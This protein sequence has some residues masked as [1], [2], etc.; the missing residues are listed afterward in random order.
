MKTIQLDKHYQNVHGVQL[1]PGTHDVQDDLARYLV[2]NGHAVY[3]ESEPLPQ[4]V[5]SIPESTEDTATEEQQPK[6]N[7]KRK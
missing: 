1:K 6:R 4:A 7:A 3:V 2:D 5:D